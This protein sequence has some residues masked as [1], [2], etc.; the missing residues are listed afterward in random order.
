[1]ATSTH[2]LSQLESHARAA[3]A[4]S[5]AIDAYDA[6]AEDLMVDTSR[7]RLLDDVEQTK[8]IMDAAYAAYTNPFKVEKTFS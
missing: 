4:H 5:E 2:G 1:M 8:I 3:K 7:Q 6:A